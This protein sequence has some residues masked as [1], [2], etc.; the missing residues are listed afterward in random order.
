MAFHK[1]LINIFVGVPFS[2]LM[3]RIGTLPKCHGCHSIVLRNHHISFV[4]NADQ[5]II[6]R[7]RTC[8]HHNNFAVIGE[9][10]MIGVT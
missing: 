5:L 3:D 8:S 6:H 7:I 10:H 4:A 9:K 2:R 1:H